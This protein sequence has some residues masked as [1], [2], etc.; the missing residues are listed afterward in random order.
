MNRKVTWKTKLETATAGN[1][2]MGCS[3]AAVQRCA[4]SERAK[5][6]VERN[7]GG[8]EP[9]EKVKGRRKSHEIREDTHN[10]PTIQGNP[11]CTNLI[12]ER[13]RGRASH[14]GLRKFK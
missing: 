14:P 6:K 3:G 1:L 8:K 2:R 10:K 7:T 5:D 11:N 4:F 13:R 9:K 12:T